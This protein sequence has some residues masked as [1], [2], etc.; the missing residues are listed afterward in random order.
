M[1]RNIKYAIKGVQNGKEYVFNMTRKAYLMLKS[2]KSLV[3]DSR[4]GIF[5]GVYVTSD[6]YKNEDR[7]KKRIN[8]LLV[9]ECIFA[10]LTVIVIILFLARIKL[11]I[12]FE[13][14]FRNIQSYILK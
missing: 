14:I 5:G 8:R 1:G 13:E 6:L 9:R 2:E 12:G 10:V 7:R 11:G 3:M 4:I